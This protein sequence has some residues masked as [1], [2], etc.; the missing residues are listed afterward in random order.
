MILRTKLYESE[1]DG[2]KMLRGRDFELSIEGSFYWPS[3]VVIGVYREERSKFGVSSIGTCSLCGYH[4]PGPAHECL[5]QPGVGM[6]VVYEKRE[7]WLNR[8]PY[9]TYYVRI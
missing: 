1:D 6:E 3:R 9:R 5:K 7:E 8:R 4:G 2:K